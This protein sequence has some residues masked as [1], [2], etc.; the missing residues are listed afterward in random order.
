VILF[1]NDIPLQ[2]GG[3]GTR[4]YATEALKHLKQNEKGQWT[5][6]NEALE[7]LVAVEIPAEAGKLLTFDQTMVHEVGDKCSNVNIMAD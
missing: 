7:Q 5:C 2:A 4:F 1:L 6:E 3:G